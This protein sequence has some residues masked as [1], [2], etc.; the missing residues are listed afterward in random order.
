M[1]INSLNKV[2]IIAPRSDREMLMEELQKSSI[3]HIVHNLKQEIEEET[4]EKELLAQ[5]IDMELSRADFVIEFLKPYERK[6]PFFQQLEQMDENNKPVTYQKLKETR[7]I[8]DLDKIYNE[9]YKLHHTVRELQSEENDLKNQIHRLEPY[10]H[11]KVRFEDIHNTEHVSMKVGYIGEAMFKSF[12]LAIEDFSKNCALFKIAE[13]VN[14]HDYCFIS[15]LKQDEAEI[16]KILMRFNFREEELNLKGNAEEEI[17]KIV[18]RQE[19]IAIEKEGI[20]KESKLRSDWLDRV[21]LYY[22][23]LLTELEKKKAENFLYE[24]KTTFII[25]GWVREDDMDDLTALMKK[26]TN[27]FEM[28]QEPPADNESVPVEL[29]NNSFIKPMELI[30]EMY[31][32]PDYRAIDPTPIYF[33]FFVLFFG[34]CL[35]DAGYGF[36]IAIGAFILLKYLKAQGQAAGFLKLLIY[37]GVA[38]IFAGLLT[39]G[40]FGI[41]QESLPGF[42]QV[43]NLKKILPQGLNTFCFDPAKDALK[44]LSITFYLGII[45]T[46]W[47]LLVGSWVLV[48]KKKKIHW[49]EVIE[50]LSWAFLFAA[51]GPQLVMDNILGTSPSPFWGQIMGIVIKSTFLILFVIKFI[52]T[53]AGMKMPESTIGKIFTPL[54]TLFKAVVANALEIVKY[55]IDIVSNILSYSRLMA[56]GLATGQIAMA[57]NIVASL[58]NDMLPVPLNH[59]VAL[60]ILLVGHT[61]NIAINT[62]GALV[63]TARL[64]YVE[65]F[66]F[67][68]EGGGKPFQPFSVKTQYNMVTNEIK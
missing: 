3:L 5:E 35:T 21:R 55:I 19:T 58:S 49:M 50:K 61:F 64:Q 29:V 36:I 37:G 15:Y 30:T 13:S 7:K 20:E 2:Y 18:E 6:L 22:D 14:K 59:V 67:F 9:C 66:P 43:D 63:H 48:F 23:M 52:Q 53:F 8:C 12:H 65:F 45:E 27:C 41:S 10:K 16:E 26:H 32:F 24:T 4:H 54:L 44:F 51:L 38:A 62:L 57:I 17:A 28:I 1:A 11:L 39:G 34:I 68:F 47:G 33:A 25:K 60:L 46:C 40:W 56:L 31:S 42:L